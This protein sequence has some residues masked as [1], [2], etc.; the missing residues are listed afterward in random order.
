MGLRVVP[1]IRCQTLVS[2]NN[3]IF[4]LT[5]G[6]SNANLALNA[7]DEILSFWLAPSLLGFMFAAKQN[8]EAEKYLSY[9]QASTAVHTMDTG[10]HFESYSN[11]VHSSVTWVN[12]LCL[13]LCKG[14]SSVRLAI[15]I[16]LS[17]YLDLLSLLG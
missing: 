13:C 2:I 14:T 1:I 3:H 11:F 15:P 17:I 5:I 10:F 6:I 12:N 7:H 16:Y 4:F 8:M 9:I